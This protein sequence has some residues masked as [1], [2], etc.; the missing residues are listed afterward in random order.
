MVGDHVYIDMSGM[1]DVGMVRKNNEDSFILADFRTGALYESPHQ[2]N[3]TLEDNSLLLVVSDGVGGSSVGEI[4]SQL[5]VHSINE[6]LGRLSWAIPAYDRLVAAVE[7]A[8][9]VV[10]NESQSNSEYHGMSATAT[11]VLVERDR[12]YIAEVGDSRAYLLRRNRITQLTTD[13]SFVEV[14]IAKGVLTPDQAA[15]HPRKNVIL[16]AVGASEV[17]QVAVGQLSLQQGDCLLLCSDGLSNNV[18]ENEMLQ[19]VRN[20]TSL[21]DACNELISL[22][23]ARGGKDNITVVL[24]RFDGDALPITSSRDLNSPAVE[25]LATFDPD[26]GAEKSHKRTMLLSDPSICVLAEH[27]LKSEKVLEDLQLYPRKEEVIARCQRTI[28]LLN[29]ALSL[30]EEQQ[31]EIETI[32]EWLDKSNCRYARM[33]DMDSKLASAHERIE[34]AWRSLTEV[35]TE[36]RPKQN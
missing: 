26:R 7:Q 25:T 2:Q 32:T 34:Q 13:Q 22:A 8:N 20:S 15:R 5:T 16:Q 19:I 28:E 9:Y 31:A 6:A 10:W 11:A 36:F 30:L 21:S 12:A 33:E 3:R 27:E 18:L 23:N 29:N 17:V 4:A 1:T 24:A 35:A 14:L